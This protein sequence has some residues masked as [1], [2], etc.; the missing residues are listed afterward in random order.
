MSPA[1][2]P[3]TAS[4]S[5]SPNCRPRTDAATRV[6]RASGSS[7]SMRAR[8]TFST[9]GGTSSGASWTKR[10]PS[11]SWTT[12]PASTSDRISSS[13]KN[14]LP[15]AGSRIRRSTSAGSV[16]SP[17]SACEQ[18]AP[19]IAGQRIQRHIRDP[20]RELA[21]DRPP[22]RATTDDRA[23]AGTSGPAAAAW[24]PCRRTTART[25]A[26]TS[27]RPSA[28]PRARPPRARPACRRVISSRTTSNVRYCSASGRE[29]GQPFRR[30]GLQR[31]TEQRRQVRSEL[32]ERAIR[33]TARPSG[34]ARRGP[35]APARPR[36]RR[37]RPAGGRGTAS[38]AGT[39]RT[40]RTYPRATGLGRA[41]ANRRRTGRGARPAAASCRSPAPR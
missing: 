9:V 18:L 10:H 25:A 34:G 6:S 8:M 31:Q 26:T 33:T 28:G 20:V 40:T 13:R 35:A 29:L 3:A 15:S 12:A 5:G 16:S 27:R 41:A 24:S 23:P 21:G 32:S 4:S 39:R 14:G 36:G 19:G 11:S 17:T 7:R 37:S 1:S 30:V 38:T 22:S 2:G